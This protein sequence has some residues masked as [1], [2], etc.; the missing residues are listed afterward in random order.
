MTSNSVLKIFLLCPIPENQKPINE[1]INLQEN[2]LTSF[3]IKNPRINFYFLF[4]FFSIFFLFQQFQQNEKE[5]SLVYIFSPSCWFTIFFV[6]L[7]FLIPF[8]RWSQLETR[9]NQSRLFYEE[10]SWYDGQIW[11]KPFLVIKN[12]RLLASQKIQ[13]LLQKLFGRILP[14]LF[15]S[16]GTL[17][18]LLTKQ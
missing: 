2:F 8:L 16:L 3:F 15:I 18:F 11:D 1:Y 12:D 10:G 4:L 13:P 9:L 7:L 14:F 6:L 17:I 5:K